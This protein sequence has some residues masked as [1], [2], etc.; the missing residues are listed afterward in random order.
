MP[1]FMVEIVGTEGGITLD[2]TG[3][4]VGRGVKE[5]DGHAER[6]EFRGRRSEQLMIR[7]FL[8]AIRAGEEVPTPAEAGRYA[9][10][11]CWAALQSAREGQPVKL[12]LNPANYPS[13]SVS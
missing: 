7:A 8:E 4:L 11:L 10:E 3:L 9:V 5:S 12:P 1:A 2:H 6:F 13:Y